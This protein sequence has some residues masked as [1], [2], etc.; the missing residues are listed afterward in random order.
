[1]SGADTST[2]RGRFI[3]LEGVEGAGKSTAMA[4]AG[5]TL[6]ALG[7]DPVVTREPGGTPLGEAIRS[8]LL[9]HR[10]AGMSARAE[11][12]LVF[13]ARAEHLDK[14][15]APALA[16]GKTVLCDRFT[17]ASYAYQGAGRA[18]GAAPIATLEEWTQGGLRPDLVLLLDLPVAQGRARTVGRAAPPD[19]FE[20]EQDG[21]FERV[22]ACYRA[23]AEADPDRYRIIDASQPRAGVAGQIQDCLRRYWAAA[24]AGA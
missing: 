3:V 23:R 22:R 4:V 8:L 17:D 12:L 14:R 6:A 20:R 10:Q 9:D 2:G 11:A 18:L 21:F 5:E 13:A 19:R 1:M 7:A 15:I 16:G 24:G